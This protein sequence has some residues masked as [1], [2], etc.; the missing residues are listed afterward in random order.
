MVDE[1]EVPYRKVGA[2]RFAG[3]VE[4]SADA[5]QGYHTLIHRP[6]EEQHV[7]K[8]RE[9]GQQIVSLVAIGSKHFLDM[10]LDSIS[11]AIY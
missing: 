1:V 3:K 5:S 6:F 2:N 7:K 11:A 9:T 8:D 10:E 4:R